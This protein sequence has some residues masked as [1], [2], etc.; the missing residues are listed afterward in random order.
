[1]ILIRAISLGLLALLIASGCGAAMH[2]SSAPAT[3]ALHADG[4][5]LTR[6]GYAAGASVGFEATGCC[7]VGTYATYWK[8]LGTGVLSAKGDRD[9]TVNRILDGGIELG[10]VSPWLTDRLRLRVR[11]G[12]TGTPPR[13]ASLGR[14]GFSGSLSALFRLSDPAPPAVGQA[15]PEIDLVLGYA[16]WGLE[17]ERTSAGSDDS[18]RSGGSLMLGLRVGAS[19]GLDLQ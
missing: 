4:D 19:H 16:I 3:I 6:S 2:A 11:A 10:A 9:N 5:W 14:Q 17:G 18:S 1:M 12:M 8:L 15:A 7:S 13:T